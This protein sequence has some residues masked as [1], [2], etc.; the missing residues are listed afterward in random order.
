LS[1]SL[2]FLQQNGEIT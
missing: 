2:K 1:S